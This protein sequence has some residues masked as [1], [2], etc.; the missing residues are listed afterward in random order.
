MSVA[1]IVVVIIGLVGAAL[2]IWT[3][4]L[5]P[6]VNAATRYFR[7]QAEFWE[8]Q[9]RYARELDAQV[10]QEIGRPP[11]AEPAPGPPPRMS[12]YAPGQPG[13]IGREGRDA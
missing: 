9:N 4:M 7:A 11:S 12:R 2:V 10:K 5:E 8:A 6:L 13:Q 1:S 3:V